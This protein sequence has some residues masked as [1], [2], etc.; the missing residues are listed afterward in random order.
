MAKKVI[1][2]GEVTLPLSSPSSFPSYS[3]VP[4]HNPSCPL[5]AFGL[6]TSPEI[7]ARGTK[8]RWGHG[9]A[10]PGMDLRCL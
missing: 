4:S 10:E 7:A 5:C 3:H 8:E 9:E 1:K 2:G 6:Q